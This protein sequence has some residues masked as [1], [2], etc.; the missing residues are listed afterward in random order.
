MAVLSVEPAAMVPRS[1]VLAGRLRLARDGRVL[2]ALVALGIA[3]AMVIAGPAG[4]LEVWRGLGVPTLTPE[5]A[6]ARVITSAWEC[7]RRSFDVLAENPC[8][9]WGRPLNYPRLWLLPGLLGWGQEQTALLALAFAIAFVVAVL[10]LA[11]PLGLRSTLVYLAALG[12]PSALL[13]IERG[14]NDQAMFALIVGSIIATAR[15]HRLAAGLAVLA[16]AV[17]K[18]YPVAA[19]GALRGSATRILVLLAAAAYFVA[20]LQDVRLIMV[21]TPRNASLS[22]GL[23]TNGAVLLPMIPPLVS[24]AVLMLVGTGLALWVATRTPTIRSDQK[25]LS[26]FTAGALIFMA[27]YIL[28]PSWDY[29]LIFLLLCLPLAIQQAWAG[30]PGLVLITVLT[31]WLSTHDASPLFRLGQLTQFLLAVVLGAMLLRLFLSSQGGERVRRLLTPPGA[32]PAVE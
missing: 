21:A 6:D 17:L 19:V 31:L 5:F 16:A 4:R 1:A 20:S 18:F 28:G 22:Y 29:R 3:L 13:A 26:A 15:G 25:A 23:A 10:G 27:T 30:S 32:S 24:T 14:N 9:R 8:D 11:G 2:L 7:A 12:S